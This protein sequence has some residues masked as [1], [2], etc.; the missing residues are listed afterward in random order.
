M[1]G[2]VQ[3]PARM[4]TANAVALNA[5]LAGADALTIDA[6]SVDMIGGLCLEILADAVA[7]RL[8]ADAPVAF[9]DPSDAFRAALATLGLDPETLQTGGISR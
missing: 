4:D 1:S 5:R 6:G 9:H 2:Q 8:A 3:L 7:R